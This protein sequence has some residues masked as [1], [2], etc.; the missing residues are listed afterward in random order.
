LISAMYPGAKSVVWRSDAIPQV[1]LDDVPKKCM[2][3]S[4]EFITVLKLHI[5]KQIIWYIEIVRI[6]NGQNRPAKKILAPTPLSRH[7]WSPGKV[8][9]FTAGYYRY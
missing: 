7:A 4:N 2:N 1:V 6:I 5:V 3:V 9:E 8:I